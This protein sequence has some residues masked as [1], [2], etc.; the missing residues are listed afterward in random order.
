MGVEGREVFS[1][2]CDC[3]AFFYSNLHPKWQ[4]VEHVV[5]VVVASLFVSLLAFLFAGQTGPEKEVES[6]CLP[7]SINQDGYSEK[8]RMKSVYLDLYTS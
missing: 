7:T 4:P 3:S 5:V 6:E 2:G 1:L 8:S